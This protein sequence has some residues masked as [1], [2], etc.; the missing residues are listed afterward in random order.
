MKDT[1]DLSQRGAIRRTNTAVEEHPDLKK[2]QIYDKKL[3]ESIEKLHFHE[4]FKLKW[5]LKFITVPNVT[6]KEC[7]IS[8]YKYYYKNIMMIIY[9]L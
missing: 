9:I 1:A 4:Q 3:N 5:E 2:A 7:K 6:G 8:E